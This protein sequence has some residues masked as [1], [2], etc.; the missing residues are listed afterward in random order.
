MTPDHGMLFD[1][2]TGQVETANM[3]AVLASLTR[4]ELLL[5]WHRKADGSYYVETDPFIIQELANLWLPCDGDAPQK[6]LQ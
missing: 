5:A 2:P 6:I 4:L 3:E 1:A